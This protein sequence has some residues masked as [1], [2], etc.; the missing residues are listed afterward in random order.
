M[1]MSAPLAREG[2]NKWGFW[3]K[4]R[5]LRPMDLSSDVWE[6]F[7]CVAGVKRGRGMTVRPNA[8]P[9]DSGGGE[10]ES[11]VSPLGEEFVIAEEKF[12]HFK[13]PAH[14]GGKSHGRP[15]F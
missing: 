10:G 11:G 8:D 6:S 15:D 9:T 13:H 1:A 7:A 2:R 14:F 12:L 5:V 4:E 3:Q